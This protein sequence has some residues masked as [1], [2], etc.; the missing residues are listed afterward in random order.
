MPRVLALRV[1]GR[2][3]WDGLRWAWLFYWRHVLLIAGISLVPAC[4]EPASAAGPKVDDP[5]TLVLA[6]SPPERESLLPGTQWTMKPLVQREGKQC[7]PAPEP[8]Q[9]VHDG[10]DGGARRHG[11]RTRRDVKPVLW[12]NHLRRAM[13]ADA[14]DRLGH[15]RPAPHDCGSQTWKTAR[16][17]GVL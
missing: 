10:D 12:L 2:V 1:N 6:D 16:H 17:A 9:M 11:L 3:V 4:E 14:S 7:V 15:D 8:V 5:P 13:P